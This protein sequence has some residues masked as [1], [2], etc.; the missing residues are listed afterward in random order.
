MKALTGG[1]PITGA[2]PACRAVRVRARRQAPGCRQHPPHTRAGG[3]S[4]APPPHLHPVRGHHPAEER[5][6]DLAERLRPEWP[7]ILRWAIDGCLAY[8]RDG[9]APPAAVSAETD[10]YIRTED[11]LVAWI[12]ECCVVGPDHFNGLAELYESWRTWAAD[13][14]ETVGTQRRFSQ[15]LKAKGYKTFR[16]N[17]GRHAFY[18][19]TLKDQPQGRIGPSRPGHIHNEESEGSEE[20]LH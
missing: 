7:A 2:A 17:G 8:R 3:R 1:D 11:A 14:N 16:W 13:A 4:H 18:D 15:R 19:I 6:P 20:R 5:D 9:L 12:E 10:D